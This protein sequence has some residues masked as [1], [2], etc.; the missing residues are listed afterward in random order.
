MAHR[1]PSESWGVFHFRGQK[2]HDDDHP[3]PRHLRTH[4]GAQNLGDIGMKKRKKMILIGTDCAVN[5]VDNDGYDSLVAHIGGYIEA[6]QM[7]ERH[8]AYIDEEGKLK[9]LPPNPVATLMWRIWHPHVTDILCGPCLIVGRVHPKTGEVDGEDHEYDQAILTLARSIA[10]PMRVDGPD[11]C[12]AC[13]RG[14]DG[15]SV[16]PAVGTLGVILCEDCA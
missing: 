10:R 5:V 11:I 14:I 1:P 16:R 2:Q 12:V 3:P 13:K 9:R 8:V 7:D 4:T 6:V 15:A